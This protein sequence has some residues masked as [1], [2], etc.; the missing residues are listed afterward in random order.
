MKLETTPTT[1]LIDELDNIEKQIELLNLKYELIRQELVT[2]FPFLEN[3]ELFQE[4][5]KTK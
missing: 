3:Q 4:K 5:T 2:R 1:T